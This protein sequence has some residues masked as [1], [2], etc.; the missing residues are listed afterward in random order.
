MRRFRRFSSIASHRDPRDDP[1]DDEWL[2]QPEIFV[3]SA[4]G[5]PVFAARRLE[6]VAWSEDPDLLANELLYWNRPEYAVGHGCAAE[7]TRTRR[8]ANSATEVRTEVLPTYERARVDP[9]E[10]DDAGLDMR[11]LGGSG[12]DGVPGARLRELLTPLARSTGA[13][14]MTALQA[15]LLPQV[16][17]KL[18]ESAGA[19]RRL[20]ARVRADDGGH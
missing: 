3:R 8:R 20:Q 4:D 15:Q 18:T 1:E 9:R 2:F 16:P 10:S 6:D 13:G 11:V 7:W 19:C 12:P 17:A 14:S 5:R